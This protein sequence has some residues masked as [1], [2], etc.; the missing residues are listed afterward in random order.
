[1][2]EHIARAVNAWP[3][4]VPDAENAI[5]I[6]LAEHGKLLRAPDAGGGQILIHAGLEMN[7]VVLEKGFR[8]P[9]ALVIEAKGRSAIAGDKSAGL[10]ACRRIALSLHDGNTHQRLRAGDEHLPLFQLI[11]VVKT[12]LD[13]ACCLAHCHLPRPGNNFFYLPPIPLFWLFLSGL[14]PVRIFLHIAYD[15]VPLQ[16]RN[17]KYTL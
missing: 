3:L 9:Q 12:D 16:E 7:V 5:E 10:E 15:H 8:L 17:V 1:M 11:L 4:A 13:R 14:P 6:G 2:S